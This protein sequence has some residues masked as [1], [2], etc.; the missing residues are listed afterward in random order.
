[1]MQTRFYQ[2]S[3]Y[4]RSDSLTSVEREA[5]CGSQECVHKLKLQFEIL[6]AALSVVMDF[7]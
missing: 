2:N 3:K 7:I 4:I 6:L 5:Y 1:M